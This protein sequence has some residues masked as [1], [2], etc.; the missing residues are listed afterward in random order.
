MEELKNYADQA[1]SNNGQKRLFAEDAAKGFAFIDLCRR[2]FDVVL[3]NP[4]FGDAANNAS[5]YLKCNYL[6]ISSNLFSA[7]IDRGGQISSNGKIGAITDATWIKKT[8]YKDFRELVSKQLP[9]ESIVDLGWG[10]LDD[11]NVATSAYI[12]ETN[13][14]KLQ[15]IFINLKDEKIAEKQEVLVEQLQNMSKGR[16][17]DRLYIRGFSFFDNFEKKV[18]SYDAPEYYITAFSTWDRLTWR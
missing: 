16:R 12:C 17:A 7:F 1:E 15:P 6:K 5:V 14:S 11:A 4:P 13:V 9:I 8:D 3:M 2:R 18:F 10:V